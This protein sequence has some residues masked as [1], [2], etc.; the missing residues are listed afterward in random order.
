LL[1]LEVSNAIRYVNEPVVSF[2]GTD[3]ITAIA[4]VAKF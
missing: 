4:L 2:K 1:S 3:A